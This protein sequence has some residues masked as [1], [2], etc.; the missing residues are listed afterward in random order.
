MSDLER[1]RR[2]IEEARCAAER[3]ALIKKQ[4]AERRAKAEGEHSEREAKYSRL[5][6]IRR[7][8]VL[9]HAQKLLTDVNNELF[10]GKGKIGE[11]KKVSKKHLLVPEGDRWEDRAP[12]PPSPHVE[13]R[14]ELEMSI[15]EYGPLRIL[16]PLRIGRPQKVDAAPRFLAALLE[17]SYPKEVVVW[18]GTLQ[19][20]RNYVFI[21]TLEESGP[22][23]GDVGR[24]ELD[25]FDG[26]FCCV[27]SGEGIR[28]TMPLKEFESAFRAGV[29]S[30]AVELHK[31]SFKPR[32]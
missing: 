32:G 11:W 30:A 18:G 23:F 20:A 21:T 6:Q 28:L 27:E 24:W 15:P 19:D 31:K 2:E 8:Y 13:E 16:I 10:T 5:V 26:D 25:G 17:I 7:E 3:E 29:I 4:E 12:G 9:S 14:L 1:A 22:I